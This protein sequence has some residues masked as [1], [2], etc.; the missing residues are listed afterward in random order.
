MCLTKL[1]D[2]QCSNFKSAGIT[3]SE[4]LADSMVAEQLFN[5]LSPSVKEFVLSKR[6]E[7]SE[8]IAAEADLSFQ[9]SKVSE[10]GSLLCQFGSQK[11]GRLVSGYSNTTI[12]SFPTT[13]KRNI[14]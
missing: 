4:Q 8:Q 12:V 11:P 3:T 13:T 14:F 1:R 10:Q 9:C 5:M 2:V 7:T 6:S